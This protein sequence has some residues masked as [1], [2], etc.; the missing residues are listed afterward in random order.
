MDLKSRLVLVE[1]LKSAM[2]VVG[3]PVGRRESDGD[4][5][6]VS[7]GLGLRPGN[8]RRAPPADF[9][10]PRL[11]LLLTREG[12]TCSRDIFFGSIEI[13]KQGIQASG[14]SV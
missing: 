8:P 13:L 7:R 3:G 2:V 5:K 14:K 9:S 10:P 1:N 4:R 12:R 6:L 11:R